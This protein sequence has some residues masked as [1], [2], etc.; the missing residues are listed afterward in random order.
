MPITN[1]SIIDPGTPKAGIPVKKATLGAIVLGICLLG[2]LWSVISAPSQQAV[3]PTAETRKAVRAEAGRSTSIDDE[4][5]LAKMAVEQEERRQAEEA[6]RKRRL[7]GQ[8][9]LVNTAP[10][11]TAA[12]QTAQAP[13]NAT[14]VQSTTS[15]PTAATAASSS[16]AKGAESPIPPGYRRGNQDAA[17]Y[18]GAMRRA[19]AQQASATPVPAGPSQAEIDAAKRATEVDALARTAKSLAFDQDAQSTSTTKLLGM[20]G[21]EGASPASSRSSAFGG[22]DDSQGYTPPNVQAPSASMQN[23]MSRMA[24]LYQNSASANNP[25]N[26]SIGGA[27]TQNV[28]GSSNDKAFVAETAQEGSGSSPLKSYTT[29]SRYTLHQGKVIPAVLGRNINTDLP[30]EVTAY[31]TSD[32]YDSLGNGD[33]LIPKGSVLVGQFNSDVKVG[34]ARVMFA[35]Q[36]LIMPDGRSFDLPGNRAYDLGGASGLEGDVD[37]HFFKMF[38]SS[39]MVAWMSEKVTQPA[40]VTVIG[41]GN[42]TSPAGQ[43]LVDVSRTILDRNKNIKPTITV[44]KGERINIEVKRDMEF[45]GPYNRR[46][47][48]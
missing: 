32:V 20:P 7:S 25:T 31:V 38:A 8:P 12:V 43:V 21:S 37:N 39:F 22:G 34:Q 6:E 15:A 45:P 44:D 28:G 11:Q 42:S 26:R 5:K 14:G 17:L 23:P 24:S 40:N 29:P 30:G 46:A 36:R 10:T 48:R 33:Q 1:E 16:G 41:G 13:A 3:Q 47:G 27:G 2:L 19:T 4:I 35:F 18:E 9:I